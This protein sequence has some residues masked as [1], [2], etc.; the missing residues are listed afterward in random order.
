M[1]T[2]QHRA[3]VL[4]GPRRVALVVRIALPGHTTT[5]RTVDGQQYA[6]PVLRAQFRSLL[7]GQLAV[8]H[9]PLERLMTTNNLQH[10]ASRARLGSTRGKGL[11]H[12]KRVRRARRIMTATLQR[13]VSR[14]ILGSRPTKVQLSVYRSVPLAPSTTITT[15]IQHAKTVLLVD[16]GAKTVRFSCF[17]YDKRFFTKTDSGQ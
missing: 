1:A 10:L 7:R 12:A 2:Q 5:T 13:S 4:R 3:Y 14:V 16:P 8:S 6:W 9:A 15:Q 17:P 11:Q